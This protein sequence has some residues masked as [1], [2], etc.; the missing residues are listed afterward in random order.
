MVYI[1]ESERVG[2]ISLDFGQW[3]DTATAFFY[4]FVLLFSDSLAKAFTAAKR[5]LMLLFDKRVTN[6]G[7]ELTSISWNSSEILVSRVIYAIFVTF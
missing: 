5:T 2:N 3:R 1:G 6:F 7:M 4:V